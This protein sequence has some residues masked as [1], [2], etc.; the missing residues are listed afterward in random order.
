M[1]MI[2]LLTKKRQGKPLTQQEIE[3]MIPAYTQGQIPD[4][5]MS[6]MLMAICFAGMSTQETAWLTSAMANSGQQMDLSGAGGPVADKHSTGG[7]ADSTSLVVV[8]MVAACG[9]SM[10]KMSGRGLGHTGGTLDKLEA[11]PGFDVDVS[12]ERFLS[13]LRQNGLAIV[14][15]N[16]QLAP[17]DKALYA[18]RDVTATVDSLPLI[19]SSIMSKKLASGADII[20]LDVKAGSG[21]FMKTKK[22]AFALAK[23]MVD[24]GNH[25][26]RK[27]AAVVT[28]MNQPLGRSVGN[29]LDIMET[30]EILQGKHLDSDLFRV[31]LQLGK[32]LLCLAGRAE[33]DNAAEK[34]LLEA[35]TSKR[36]LEK[37][38]IMIAAQGGDAAVCDD[39]SRLPQ[40]KKVIPILSQSAGYL[41]ETDA[42]SIGM[43]AQLLGAGRAELGDCIDPA[44]GLVMEKRLGDP[45]RCGDVLAKFYVNDEKNLQE[46]MTRFLS[47]LV[48]S[49]EKPALPPLIYGTVDADGIHQNQ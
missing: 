4:Y 19:A 25:L 2:D 41:A 27:T 40:A 13:L 49:K 7:V 29:A 38:R 15:Q 33:E 9:V 22:D 47:A 34:M 48:I 18:L 46:A 36:A 45:V 35:I 3:W 42:Q 28:D 39:P 43:C 16:A 31:C 1:H 44:V 11:I 5:Q 12:P 17:A 32:R 20:V 21:A 37:L 8:P 6:A 30:I 23:T 24:I 14:G 26:H 10:A